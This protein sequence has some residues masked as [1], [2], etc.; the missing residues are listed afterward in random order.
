MQD[1]IYFNLADEDYHAEKRLS[2]SG[3]RDILDNPTY[4]WFNS[5]FNPLRIEKTSEA[6]TDGKIMHSMILEGDTFKNKYKVMPLEIEGLSRNST[7][8]KIWKSAQSLEVIPFQ[9]YKKF[10]LICDYLSQEGQILDCNIFNGGFAEVSILW[11]ENGIKRK[12]RI[13]YLTLGR[14]IDLK[15]FIKRNK[16]PLNDYVAEYFFSYKVYIQLVYYLRAV[17]FALENDLKVF[18][19]SEQL[20]FWEELR[21]VKDFLL[22]VAFVNR[23]LPQSAL[24][25][26]TEDKCADV[27]RLAEKQISQAEETYLD[28]MQRYGEKSAWLQET[29]VNADDLIFTDADFPQIFYDLLKGGNYE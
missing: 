7:E 25:V 12:A 1:G 21:N 18:G 20:N 24:K 8:F 15:T 9:K 5:N 13:D 17:K 11:T 14:I 10:K 29:D 2:S 16:K 3:L 26:F 4:Y 6:M 28:Y 22:M 19:N 27:W 23:E